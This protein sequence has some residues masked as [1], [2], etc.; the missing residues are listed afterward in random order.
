MQLML[1]RH[2]LGGRYQI[3]D[4]TG[5]SVVVF[6]AEIKRNIILRKSSSDK[7]VFFQVYVKREY[8]AIAKLIGN[9]AIK[10]ILDIGSNVGYTAVYFHSVFADADIY[11]IEPERNNYAQILKNTEGLPRIHAINK[12]AWWKN[13]TLQIERG[14]RDK[15]DWAIQVKEGDAMSDDVEAITINGLCSE[16]NMPVID[17]LKMDIEGAE[18]VIFENGKMEEVLERTRYIAIEI[19]DEYDCRQHICDMLSR[20]NFYWTQSGE[21]VIGYNKNLVQR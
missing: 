20:N 19:H 9:D 18:K 21:L 10:T 5:D 16:L 11:S 2:H 8:A 7:D 14:F 6:D 3:T 17:L 4:I 13:T 1:N 15:R 12:A